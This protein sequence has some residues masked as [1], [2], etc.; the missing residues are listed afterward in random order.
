MPDSGVNCRRVFFAVWPDAPALD[1][2]NALAVRSKE[3]CGGR[4]MRKDGL[5]MTLVFV[6]AVSPAQLALLH[7]V[8]SQVRLDPFEARFDHL[9][10]WRHNRIIWAGCHETPSRQRRLFECLSQSLRMNGFHVDHRP[11][12]PHVTLLRNAHGDAIPEMPSPICWQVN[13]F[14]LVESLLQPSGA[15]YRTLA[16]WRLVESE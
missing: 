9:G 1:A 3:S 12:M 4:R 5:H 7:A 10:W 6:G 13:E 14:C 16:C 11:W 15:R 2:L 8:G